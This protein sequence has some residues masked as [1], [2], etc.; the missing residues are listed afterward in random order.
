[1]F[2]ESQK[3]PRMVGSKRALD[4]S[5]NTSPWEEISTI[6]GIGPRRMTTEFNKALSTAPLPYCFLFSTNYLLF[7]SESQFDSVMVDVHISMGVFV[8]NL[9]HS[10]ILKICL[11]RTMNTMASPFNGSS[12][13]R[14][15]V[16]EGKSTFPVCRIILLMPLTKVC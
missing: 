1:M 2:P 12:E 4:W 15:L 13:K 16:G 5:I 6:L 11:S 3:F 8:L 10:P 9:S 7:G 14:S